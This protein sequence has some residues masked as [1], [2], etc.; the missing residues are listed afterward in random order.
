LALLAIGQIGILPALRL[1][2]PDVLSLGGGWGRKLYAKTLRSR[3]WW[4][5]LALG[6]F[7]GFLPC[8]LTYTAAIAAAGTLSALK[9]MIVMC[10]F[11]V[12]TMPGLVTLALSECSLLKLFP[13]ARVRI[14]IGAMSGWIMA[15]MAIVFIARALPFLHR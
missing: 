6:F 1:P 9:G 5:P 12:C 10:V 15:A 11:C 4:Q 7:V 2:E 13:Q 3:E 8:G 14:V